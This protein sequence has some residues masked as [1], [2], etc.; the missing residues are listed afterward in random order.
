MQEDI[1]RTKKPFSGKSKRDKRFREKGDPVVDYYQNQQKQLMLWAIDAFE[2]ANVS[3]SRQFNE[4]LSRLKQQVS[5]LS[6]SEY[7]QSTNL[8]IA[9][10]GSEPLGG[11]EQNV[12][13]LLHD[14]IPEME[15]IATQTMDQNLI[16]A[17]H[18]VKGIVGFEEIAY[19]E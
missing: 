7:E 9:V 18:Q 6:D 4:K 11:T 13:F 3:K 15:Q 10:D 19:P 12:K 1:L 17:V 5:G 14:L 16:S 8:A 2:K